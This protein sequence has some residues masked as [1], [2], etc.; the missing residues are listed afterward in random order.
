MK[1]RWIVSI[2]IVDWNPLKKT[3][4][5]SRTLP[6]LGTNDTVEIERMHVLGSFEVYWNK[7][8]K[9]ISD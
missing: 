2:I 9:S 7:Q 6:Q 4:S 8:R 5:I 3:G 1:I